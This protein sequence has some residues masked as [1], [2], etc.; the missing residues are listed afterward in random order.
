[1]TKHILEK[2]QYDEDLLNLM[3]E[4]LE[5]SGS[6][7]DSKYSKILNNYGGGPSVADIA[8]CLNKMDLLTPSRIEWTESNLKKYVS[9]I[10]ERTKMIVGAGVDYD[11]VERFEDPYAVNTDRSAEQADEDVERT[12]VE[13]MGTEE[14]HSK[15]VMD[16]AMYAD[17]A[18][19]MVMEESRSK[20]AMDDAMYADSKYEKVLEEWRSKSVMSEIKRQ[21]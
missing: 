21:M 20:Y 1:M 8:D 15:Y 6:D 19:E 2:T 7:V 5:A 11:A 4:M 13:M 16:G 9:R 3:R 10:S 17:G 14:W 12:W 18:Y